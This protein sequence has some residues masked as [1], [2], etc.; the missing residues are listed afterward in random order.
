MRQ[1]ETF[2]L[3]NVITLCQNVEYA[4]KII[5]NPV[6]RWI[7]SQVLKAVNERPI[8]N[9]EDS[10]GNRE[11]D[12]R[13][14]VYPYGDFLRGH[15]RPFLQG[16]SLVLLV[17]VPLR[18]VHLHAVFL[19]LRKKV[20][21][22]LRRYGRNI[23][24]SLHRKCHHHLILFTKIFSMRFPYLRALLSNCWRCS[25]CYYH[26]SWSRNVTSASC[27]LNPISAIPFSRVWESTLILECICC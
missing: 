17:L 11:D 24:E 22:A 10:E 5:W 8:K 9:I 15:G 13:P 16:R 1:D 27:S 19:L 7:F 25:C 20:V 6:R 14:L 12:P 3:V 26:L 18:H 2:C 21:V 4:T 23:P